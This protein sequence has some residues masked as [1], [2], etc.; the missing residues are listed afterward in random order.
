MGSVRFGAR[1]KAAA[2]PFE[3]QDKLPLT[4]G[5]AQIRQKKYLLF[6]R[7]YAT[8]PFAVFNRGL[9]R[10]W[11]QRFKLRWAAKGQRRRRGAAKKR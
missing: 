10:F 1:E 2:G 8:L 3:A 7:P 4:K 5:G 11:E 6:L 9:V